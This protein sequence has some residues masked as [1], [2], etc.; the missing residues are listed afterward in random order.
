MPCIHTNPCPPRFLSA[1]TGQH[2]LQFEVEYP[3]AEEGLQPRH[4]FMSAFEQ[5]V[6]AADKGTDTGV[7]MGVGG[8]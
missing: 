2:G 4:R 7:G 1:G 8:C 5:R 3:E 6:E